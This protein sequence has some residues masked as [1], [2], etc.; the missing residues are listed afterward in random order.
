VLEL[1]NL[2][3]ILR[4]FVG[5]SKPF[6]R[7]YRDN[8]RHGSDDYIEDSRFAVDRLSCIH[9]YHLLEKDLKI[10]FDYISPN[11]SNNSTFSHRIYELFFRACTEFENNA[12]AILRENRYR[13]AG[14]WNIT[15]YFKINQALFLHSYL[16]KLNVWES[17]P[18][19][20]QPFSNWQTT[21]SLQWYQDYNS[22]KHDRT[23]NFHLANLSNLMN[24]M[25]GLMAVLFAQFAHSSFSPYQPIGM[26]DSNGGFESANDSLFQVRP[27]LFASD[28]LYDFDWNVL[29]GT[30]SPFDSFNFI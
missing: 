24:A 1:C 13:R 4:Y 8:L 21:H 30:V 10:L 17:G 22:V 20:L 18:L 14:Y 25:A 11:T 6:V 29:K 19:T 23:N 9:S 16:I 2:E 12:T 27:H 5:L 26:Y 7:V 15:D 28:D 3:K